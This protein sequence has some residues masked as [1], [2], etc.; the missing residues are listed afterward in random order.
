MSVISATLA[1]ADSATV[2]TTLITAAAGLLGVL[3]GGLITL[4]VERQRATAT[5][6]REVEREQNLAR[7]V[8]RVE[9]R[10]LVHYKTIIESEIAIGATNPPGLEQDPLGTDDLKILYGALMQTELPLVAAAGVNVRGYHVLRT[11]L[12]V[13]SGG[14]TAPIDPASEQAMDVMITGITRGVEALGRLTPDG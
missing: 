14:P 11:Q 1:A 6:A 2:A 7:A 10:R 4:S 13:A 5:E 12:L 9:Q 3:V 8:A